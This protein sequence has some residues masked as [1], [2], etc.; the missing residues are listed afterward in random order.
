MNYRQA[1]K[2]IYHDKKWRKNKIKETRDRLNKK[3]ADSEEKVN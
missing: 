2:K 3:R 1:K